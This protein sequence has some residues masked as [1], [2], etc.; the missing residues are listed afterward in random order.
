ML[1]AYCYSCAV[2]YWMGYQ[3]F[4]L[5][6]SLE[7]KKTCL[8]Y[9]LRPFLQ[10]S[11]YFV[12]QYILPSRKIYNWRTVLNL[13]N[14]SYNT[15]INLDWLSFIRNISHS[16]LNNV[17]NLANNLRPIPYL[18]SQLLQQIFFPSIG[19]STLFINPSSGIPG[20]HMSFPILSSCTDHFNFLHYN[21]IDI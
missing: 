17:P 2:S 7:S 3:I 6:E 11:N 4:S 5:W 12:P 1:A 13:T 20:L 19:S 9:D 18:P 21:P 15:V 16:K 10:P 8:N 14:I